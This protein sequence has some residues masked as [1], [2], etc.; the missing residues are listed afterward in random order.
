MHIKCL[1]WLPAHLEGQELML[2][3]FSLSYCNYSAKKND[4]LWVYNLGALC[5]IFLPITKASHL[6]GAHLSFR[7][8]N[9]GREG[10]WELLH[11]SSILMVLPFT[12]AE[13]SISVTSAHRVCVF[14]SDVFKMTQVFHLTSQLGNYEFLGTWLC[15]SP[16]NTAK[17][18][19]PL[20]VLNLT[21]HPHCSEP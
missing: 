8:L 2:G 20:G 3:L 18:P 17:L 5:N 11:Q 6:H 14:P 12:H 13:K 9:P 16:E 15:V 7:L 1:W 4:G 21:R 10:I 19:G